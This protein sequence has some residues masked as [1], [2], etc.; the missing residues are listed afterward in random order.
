MRD[1]PCLVLDC[2]ILTQGS[3]IG[4]KVTLDRVVARL[5]DDHYSVLGHLHD[6]DTLESIPPQQIWLQSPRLPPQ[7]AGTHCSRAGWRVTDQRP[8]SRR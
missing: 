2:A 8:D 1:D 7:R 5:V 6:C 4:G 3:P